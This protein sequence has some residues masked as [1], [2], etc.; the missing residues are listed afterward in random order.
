MVP[1]LATPNSHQNLPRDALAN[2]LVA[3]Q[4]AGNSVLIPTLY[5]G[6]NSKTPIG[7]VFGITLGVVLGITLVIMIMWWAM[8]QQAEG[9]IVE[10]RHV[11]IGSSRRRGSQSY[12][13]EEVRRTHSPRRRDIEIVDERSNAPSIVFRSN[14]RRRS[15]SRD[16]ENVVVYEESES[17]EPVRRP[18]RRASSRRSGYR[19]VDP[20]RLGGGDNPRR[21]VS[22][23]YS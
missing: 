5:V 21:P 22:R 11:D 3:R 19:H 10:S 6:I 17:T 4:N 9:N 12:T 1:S 2:K 14:S 23:R 20:D 18:S 7:T 15:R 13:I 16:E 8:Y